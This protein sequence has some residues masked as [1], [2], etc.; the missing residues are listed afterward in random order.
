MQIVT[1]DRYK[2]PQDSKPIILISV[3]ESLCERIEYTSDAV[4]TGYVRT[5]IPVDYIY[6][7]LRKWGLEC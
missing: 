6:Q 5:D 1:I 2:F 7:V 3:F 4:I